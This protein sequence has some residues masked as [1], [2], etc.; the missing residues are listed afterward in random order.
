MRIGT[1]ELIVVI[2]IALVVFGPGKLPELGKMLGKAIGSIKH[3]SDPNTWEKQAT[4]EE[5][6]LREKEK[7]EAETKAA[8][9]NEASEAA[10]GGSAEGEEASQEEPPMINLD[11]D[12]EIPEEDAAEFA[13]MEG[14]SLDEIAAQMS[15]AAEGKKIDASTGYASEENN[16]F[17]V[18]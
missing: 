17:E 1:T 4:R 5:E 3:Y 12:A 16:P 15:K 10:G 9:A 6:Q 18:K 7:T 14:K 2:L 13:D 8:V 11:L